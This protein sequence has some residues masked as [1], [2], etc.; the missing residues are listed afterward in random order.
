M[1]ENLKRVVAQSA[2]Y[3]VASILAVG[4]LVSLYG[5]SAVQADSGI[6]QLDDLPAGVVVLADE[7]PAPGEILHP[8]SSGQTSSLRSKFSNEEQS[9]LLGYKVVHSFAA[10]APAQGVV[11]MNFAYE[12]ATTIEAEQAAEILRGDIKSA[13]TLLQVNDIRGAKELRGQGF[14]LKGDEGDSVYWFVGTRGKNLVLLMVN[15]MEQVS[16]SSVFEST[17]QKLVNK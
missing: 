2:L 17:I 15:G 3:I 12:Y 9:L 4:V 6:L 14:L 7:F 16:V 1:H 13:P 10:L 5:I 11:I 8:L